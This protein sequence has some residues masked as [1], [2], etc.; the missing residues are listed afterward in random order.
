[1]RTRNCGSSRK[2]IR[3]RDF[4]CIAESVN[5]AEAWSEACHGHVYANVA[6]LDS[7]LNLATIDSLSAVWAGPNA[8]SIGRGHA[9]LRKTTRDTVPASL[10]VRDAATPAWWARPATAKEDV[11]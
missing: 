3:G 6:N 5:A 11:L 8:T 4:T 1:V 9:T 2:V 10:H 7:K